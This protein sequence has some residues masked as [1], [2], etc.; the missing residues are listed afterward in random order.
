MD[1]AVQVEQMQA[2]LDQKNNEIAANMDQ[3]R[4]LGAFQA[5][6][7]NGRDKI[8]SLEAKV[9]DLEKVADQASKAASAAQS[10]LA[11]QN[12]SSAVSSKKVA[13]AEDMAKA[14]KVLLGI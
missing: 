14:V 6:A 13:A 5:E 3:I 2:Q 4:S 1:L 10:A 9:A 12:N 8:A 7:L 11:A